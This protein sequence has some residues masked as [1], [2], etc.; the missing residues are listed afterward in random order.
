MFFFFSSRRR[1]T[2]LQ[3][4]WSSDVCSSDLEKNIRKNPPPLSSGRSATLTTYVDDDWKKPLKPG[5]WAHGLVTEVKSDHAIVRFGGVTAR[6]VPPDFVWTDLSHT[7]EVFSPGDV[8]LFFIK[9]VKGQTAHV[10]LDQHPDVQGALVA[11]ENSTG[12]VKALAGGYD[13]E[14]SKYNRAR[15]AGRQVGPPFK[16]YAYAPALL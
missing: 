4:D 5:T 16:A 6:V 14:E 3:G 7:A 11:I 10:T 8:D 2:R 13:F 9:D 15:Q 12:A 1:H